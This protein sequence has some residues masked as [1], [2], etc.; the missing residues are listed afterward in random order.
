VI[1]PLVQGLL[2]QERTGFALFGF[3]VSLFFASRIFRSVIGT[4]DA[5][6]R[7]EKPRG[8]LSM[9]L[10]GMM[11]AL[12]AVVVATTILSLVVVGP[13]FGG[14]WAIANWLG[15]GAAFEAAWAVARRPVVFAVAAAFLAFLYH[16]GPNVS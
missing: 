15:F 7:V 9:W 12:F 11:F 1:A 16:V 2:R 6:Y 3:L 13:L 5:A 14:G 4:L 8:V 10:L